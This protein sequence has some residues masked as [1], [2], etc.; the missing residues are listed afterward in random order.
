MTVDNELILKLENLAKLKLS[1]EEKTKLKFELEKIIGMFSEIGEVDTTGIEPLIHMTEGVN[2][3]R[4]DKVGNHLKIE[5]FES[6]APLMKDKM[7]A[8]PKVIE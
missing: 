5:N 2:H 4:D 8:V 7:F 6:N 3:W 1:D